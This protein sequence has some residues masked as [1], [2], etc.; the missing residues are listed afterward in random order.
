MELGK[1][2][3][4]KAYNFSRQYPDILFPGKTQYVTPDDEAVPV[5][6]E[7]VLDTAN[8]LTW[9]T[10]ARK[11]REWKPDVLIMRYWMSW[12][13]PSL[14]YVARNAGK[15]CKVIG[16][17]DNVVP[18]EPRFFDTPF[19]KY[20]LNGCDGFITMC[21]AVTEELLRL[22]PDAAYIM[23]NHPLY[24]HFGEKLPRQVAEK[25]LGLAGGKKNI[26]FFGLIRQ[27]KGLDILLEAFKGLSD[28]YQLIIAGEPYGSFEP[29]QRII[30]SIPGKD[31]IHIFTHYIKDSEVKDYFSAADVTVLPYRSATQSGIS[32]I[33]YHFEV[34]M[35]VTDV[36]GLRSTIGERGTGIVARET[37]PECILEEIR[38]YFR[39][40]E[41]VQNCVENI[42]KEKTRLSWHSFCR[43]LRDFAGTL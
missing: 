4:V 10:A 12:F 27:Y 29:Y 11:I 28:D 43:D 34:P 3:I 13:A 25:K 38:H 7:A 6:S 32:S 26:L 31:R 30:D 2:D 18:H 41:I 9:I 17:L 5:E 33:S 37:T 40:P 42:R 24:S 35:I 14:G 21:D 23:R 15:E 1:S 36:G 39:H 16:I 22:K 19:T 8:P 20:F